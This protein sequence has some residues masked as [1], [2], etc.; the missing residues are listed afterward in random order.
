M[1]QV[2]SLFFNALE[3]F[4]VF[5]FVWKWC[6]NRCSSYGTQ[7]KRYMWGKKFKKKTADDRIEEFFKQIDVR[8]N[9][10]MANKKK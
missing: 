4:Y 1:I 5:F 3:N 8:S 2:T 10:S 6:C 9:W 7:R